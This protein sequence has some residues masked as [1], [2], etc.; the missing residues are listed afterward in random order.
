MVY[1]LTRDAPAMRPQSL[2]GSANAAADG[3]TTLKASSSSSRSLHYVTGGLPPSTTPI[4]TIGLPTTDGPGAVTAAHRRRNTYPV[5]APTANPVLRR[6]F[7]DRA[8]HQ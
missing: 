7:R 6:H 8:I 5:P 1:F 4:P 3:P 2:G